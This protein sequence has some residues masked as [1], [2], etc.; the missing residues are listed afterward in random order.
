MNVEIVTEAPIFLSWEYLFQIFGI[1]SLQC[2]EIHIFSWISKTVTHP[3][4]LTPHCADEEKGRGTV[5]QGGG[6]DHY[7]ERDTTPFPME[8]EER[9]RQD[10]PQY[11]K[12]WNCKE[13][14][15]LDAVVFRISIVLI[16][17]RIDTD[18]YCWITVPDLDPA[19]QKASLF[20]LHIE[21]LVC[22]RY[23]WLRRTLIQYRIYENILGHFFLFFYYQDFRKGLGA[24]PFLRKGFLLINK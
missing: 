20:M 2:S 6:Y 8:E 23:L 5:L 15:A 13:D 10:K 21:F 3:L 4:P 9:I 7:G 1:L 18:P 16:R 24:K 22:L 14:F 12:P 19:V 17:I 11:S